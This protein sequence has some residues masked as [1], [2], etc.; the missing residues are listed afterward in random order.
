MSEIEK[1]LEEIIEIEDASDQEQQ[2]ISNERKC[3]RKIKIVAGAKTLLS[4]Q[5]CFNFVLINQSILEGLGGLILS[6]RK[7][8]FHRGMSM[9]YVILHKQYTSF[10]YN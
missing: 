2:G 1:A 5:S 6:T 3:K 9:H 8:D 10:Q 7:F 4:S